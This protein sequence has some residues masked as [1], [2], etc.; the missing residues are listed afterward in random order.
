MAIAPYLT[1][2]F[3]WCSKKEMPCST[4]RANLSVFNSLRVILD[5][6]TSGCNGTSILARAAAP[7]DVGGEGRGRRREAVGRGGGA[8][9]DVVAGSGGAKGDCGG[10]GDC[11]GERGGGGARRF[12]RFRRREGSEEDTSELQSLRH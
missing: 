9:R 11:G 4:S 10:S 3:L 6:K 5:T 7:G 8:R 2:S 12:Q 1:A